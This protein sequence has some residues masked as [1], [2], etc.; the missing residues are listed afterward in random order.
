M[1]IRSDT[2]GAEKSYLQDM[3]ADAAGCVLEI[4]CG[5]GRLT[6]KFHERARSVVGIDLPDALQPA[7]FTDL[8]QAQCLAASA[9]KLPFRDGCFDGAI[10]ALSF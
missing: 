6:R 4:G 9:I 2:A 10:F 3:L 1:A 5:D 8:P 7:G